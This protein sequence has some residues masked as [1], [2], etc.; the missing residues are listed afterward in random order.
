MQHDAMKTRQTQYTEPPTEI[1]QRSEKPKSV[2]LRKYSA[3]PTDR[4]LKNLE[5]I[6]KNVR[7]VPSY[8][9]KIKEFL[10][11]NPSSSMFKPVRHKFPRRRIVA[12]YP[13]EMV[14]SDTIN[15]RS[16]AVPHNRHYKYIMVCIDVFSKKAWAY[17]MKTMTE[18]DATKALE[19]MFRD[20][21][22][23]P[24]NLITDRGTEYYNSKVSALLK[25][26]GI[27][28]YSI[29]GRHK[30]SVAERFIRTLKSRLEKYFYEREIQLK[31][32]SPNWIDVL[33]QF[34]SNYN[35]T[36]HR[37][38]K[39]APSQVNENNR[40]EVYRNLYPKLPDNT[41]ARLK[42]GDKVRVV[43]AKNVFEKGYTKGWSDEIYQI[44]KVFLQ[45]DI[46]Y[47]KLAD[48]NGQELPRTKYY[49]ELNLVSRK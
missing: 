32:R 29:R 22:D 13:F 15:Y 18:I 46:D 37:S 19:H 5:E 47:Y 7:S 30:A 41:R 12:H 10:Q 21:P 35:N 43:R 36:Y 24:K 33:D 6:Y 25:R 49:W 31:R 40:K 42:K 27:H 2:E 39:M 14:M 45:N 11:E 38:I 17:P 26:L 20:M 48:L 28:H 44:E 8:S 1:N 16:I 4:T 9:A 23:L 3:K 34:V